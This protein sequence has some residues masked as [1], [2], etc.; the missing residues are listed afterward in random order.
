MIGNEFGLAQ[1]MCWTYRGVQ[2][3]SSLRFVYSQTK[4]NGGTNAAGGWGEIQL[5]WSVYGGYRF[6]IVPHDSL[7]LAHLPILMYSLFRIV[8]YIRMIDTRLHSQKP[9]VIGG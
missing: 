5:V 4:R 9:T 1:A 6:E 7:D 3:V 8:P 2:N